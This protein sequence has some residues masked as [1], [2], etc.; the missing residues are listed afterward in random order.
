MKL[1]SRKTAVK[2]HYNGL[3]M[4]PRVVFMCNSGNPEF[5][6]K[7]PD[8]RIFFRISGFFSGFPEFRKWR[9]I[10]EIRKKYRKSGGFQISDENH[11]GGWN[12]DTDPAQ[13][14]RWHIRKIFGIGPR[15]PELGPNF[16]Q[17]FQKIAIS[18]E[19]LVRFG[20]N[21]DCRVIFDLQG[22]LK[23]EIKAL[24]STVAEIMTG[25]GT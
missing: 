7:I 15:V 1:K 20:W 17:I 10:P 6:P 12:L 22:Y 5:Y 21:F 8:F 25:P 13:Y 19:P 3:K 14:S 18:R 16:G 23:S 2:L 9:K 24:K 11:S 4:S